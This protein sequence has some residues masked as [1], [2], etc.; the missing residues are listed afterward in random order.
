MSCELK[1]EP[2]IDKT[3]YSKIVSANNQYQIPFFSTYR[4]S[5]SYSGTEWMIVKSA[6]IDGET[7]YY[8]NQKTPPP[9]PNGDVTDRYNWI[10][11]P[12]LWNFY[13][14]TH[15]FVS[16]GVLDVYV[17]NESNNEFTKVDVNTYNTDKSYSVH[18]NG[19]DDS[20]VI[21]ESVEIPDAVKDLIAKK[22][23]LYVNFK[24]NDKPETF[25][26]IYDFQNTIWNWVPVTD[27]DG[28]EDFD[29]SS[30]TFDTAGVP[31]TNDVT[32]ADKTEICELMEKFMAN[33]NVSSAAGGGGSSQTSV[34]SVSSAA[35]GGGSSQTSVVSVSNNFSAND[36]IEYKGRPGYIVSI[37]TQITSKIKYIDEFFKETEIVVDNSS[38]TQL[39]DSKKT[40]ERDSSNKT[41][42]PLLYF[43]ISVGNNDF[44]K[45]LLNK[46]ADATAKT[47]DGKTPLH[48]AANYG[49]YIITDLLLNKGAD[50]NAK[51][52][53]GTT[54]LL[55]AANDGYSNIAELL[56][57]RGADV[58]ATD[59]YGI[60]PLHLAADKG[61][62]NITKLL[63]DR[64]ADVN[65]KTTDDTTPLDFATK[66][67]HTQIIE[68]LT[69]SSVISN[70]SSIVSV[71]TPLIVAVQTPDPN[72]VVSVQNP[73]P[74]SVVS[75]QPPSHDPTMM[76]QFG[77]TNEIYIKVIFDG[78]VPKTVDIVQEPTD[79][80][81]IQN[82]IEDY[83]DGL[84]GGAIQSYGTPVYFKLEKTYAEKIVN[85]IS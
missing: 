78:I 53:D 9:K 42:E 38:I 69:K 43:A 76:P 75:V 1:E 7:I 39:T 41:Q 70:T 28:N 68:L 74:N 56:L 77:N 62:F 23:R 60:T 15:T 17:L 10:F 32:E 4:E 20:H 79:K 40:Y 72:S 71:T 25:C 16:K 35:G 51:T 57:D 50:V 30:Y 19:N 13:D 36:L 26:G 63:L 73:N 44:V 24:W 54:P 81:V 48:I 21:S 85:M 45:L 22:E 33:V 59:N 80:T 84:L 66:K 58:N 37:N 67:N 12:H 2:I 82:N 11:A 31:T 5:N 29:S 64:G 46:G 83:I 14:G 52:T 3:K 61:H 8:I 55:L 65:A 27:N 47:T 6:E 34:V 49:Y 18:D